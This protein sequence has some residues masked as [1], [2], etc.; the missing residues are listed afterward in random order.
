MYLTQ[1]L[2][3]YKGVSGCV[4]MFGSAITISPTHDLLI[5]IQFRY[6]YILKLHNNVLGKTTPK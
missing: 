1:Y 4:L 3:M 5:L 6:T 2:P